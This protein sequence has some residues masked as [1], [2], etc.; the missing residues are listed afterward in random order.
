MN[1]I[2]LPAIL[3]LAAAAVA[4]L[5]RPESRA[6]AIIAGATAHLLAIIAGWFVAATRDGSV[7]TIAVGGWPGTYGIVF[8][9]DL[10]AA[11]MLAVGAYS[12]LASWWFSFLGATP[13]EDAHRFYY[14][15]LLLLASGVNWAFLTADLFNLFVAF[16]L[17]LLASYALLAHTNTGPSLRE[18]FKFVAL[19][20][21]GGTLFLAA[22]GLVYG[23]FGSLNYADLA[24]RIGET[25]QRGLALAL[26]AL[27]LAVFGMKA[28]AF[29]LFFWL[30]EAYPRA[31]LGMMPFFSGVLTKVGIYCLYR[32]ATLFFDAEMIAVYQP[33]L[34]FLAGATM[35]IGV[36]GALSQWT[37]RHIL[38]FHSISQ[39]GYMLFGL[40]LFTPIG[41][42]GGLLFVLHH[43]VV[44]SSLFL[45]AGVVILWHGSDHLKKTTSLLRT[46]PMMS[47]MFLLAALSL[48]GIPPLSG[49][50]GKYLLVFSGIQEGAYVVTAVSIATSLLTLASMMKI[51][52]YSFLGTKEDA[53][54]A[55]AV[56]PPLRAPVYTLAGACVLLALFPFVSAWLVS[57][58]DDAAAQLLLREPY[59][60]AV[61]GG[62]VDVTEVA[63]ATP[64]VSP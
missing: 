20:I 62:P 56:H 18:S 55:A 4:L 11:L 31:P 58:C 17:I 28:A 44:K 23:A 14:P 41:L 32:I 59:I 5:F 10:P 50:Y 39:I 37:F 40:A 33:V 25:D 63:S 36:L 57:A 46:H 49:F 38:A 8:A 22:A 53:P 60:A 47:L 7:H 24:L 48:A 35:F 3:P 2:L 6:P 54:P 15:L 52:S 9:L 51:W 34:L 19:N 1:A 16:E 21:V 45:A 13:R 43:A 29:P 27:L 30:P 64:E 42:S 26:G 12:F 61:L